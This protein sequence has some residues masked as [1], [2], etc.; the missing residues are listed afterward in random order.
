MRILSRRRLGKFVSHL[1]L[2]F[3]NF[4]VLIACLKKKPKP[5]IDP[6]TDDNKK[7]PEPKS[8]DPVVG[9]T[10][11][12]DNYINPD[13]FTPNLNSIHMNYC[14]GITIKFKMLPIAGEK[15]E[16]ET[17]CYGNIHSALFVLHFPKYQHGNLTEIFIVHDSGKLIAQK[18]ILNSSDIADDDT[19]LP[20]IFDHIFIEENTKYHL[21]LKEGGKS[22]SRVEISEPLIF[23][24]KFQGLNVH[25]FRSVSFPAQE[26]YLHYVNNIFSP[27]AEQ[28]SYITDKE[29]I[30]HMN[31]QAKFSNNSQL[32]D[33]VVTDLLGRILADEGDD[34][35]DFTSYSMIICYKK[36]DK[37]YFLR[38][39]VKIV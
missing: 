18:G 2:M 27:N 3:L 1:F 4:F 23:E 37:K 21:I 11:E 8:E 6:K 39:F 34:F 13:I 25:S 7:K 19:I 12:E 15:F 33:Y 17:K 31:Y 29:Q 32:K 26:S 9:N 28:Y 20:I 5:N 38:T 14:S 30:I 35:N 24:K 10:I 16:L 36:V 22:Y